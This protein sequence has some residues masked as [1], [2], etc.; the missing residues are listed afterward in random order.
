VARTCTICS[1]PTRHEIDKR[2]ARPDCNL[3]ALARELGLHRTSVTRHRDSHLARHGLLVALG[4]Q[5]DAL[6]SRALHAQ[7]QALYLKALETL[8]AIEAGVV[9]GT[10]K[11]GNP[12]MRRSMTQQLKAIREVRATIET[13]A[14]L[15]V[16]MPTAGESAS[17]GARPDLDAAVKRALDAAMQRRQIVAASEQGI[18]VND[19]GVADAEIVE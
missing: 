16:A 14:R 17:A 18:G 12:V 6:D 3:S 9:V 1:L 8:S 19:D 4:A 2:L 13:L 7:A 5:A 11:D 10:D 15:A